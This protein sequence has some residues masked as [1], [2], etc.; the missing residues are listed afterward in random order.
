MI[1]LLDRKTIGILK[2]PCLKADAMKYVEIYEDFLKQLRCLGMSIDEYSN[3]EGKESRQKELK[4]KGAV[5]KNNG[6]S[7]HVNR[8]SPAC[9]A[10]EKGI[11]SRTFFI[12]FN[13]NRD[14]YFCFNYNMKDY[15]YYRSNKKDYVRDLELLYQKTKDIDF[16]GLSGGEPLL[17]IDDV[18]LFYR[19]GRKLF[20]QAYTRLYTNGDYIDGGVLEK[21]RS[22][23]LDEIRFS[24]K[25]EDFYAGRY[26][27]EKLALS[28]KYISSVMVEMPVEPGSFGEMKEILV[29][30]DEVGIFGINLLEMLCSLV[31]CEEYS[32]RSFKIKNP[33]WDVLYDYRYPGTVPIAESELDCLDLLKFVV[34]KGLRLGVHYCS[35]ENKHTAQIYKQNYGKKL[36]KTHYCSNKDYFL[37]SAKV[38]GGDIPEVLRKFK[39]MYY[40]Q[41]KINKK[42]ELVEFNVD[43]IKD[44]KNLDLEVG[45]STSVF[46][47]SSVGDILRELKVDLTY[48]EVF[49][50]DED[51]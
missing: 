40:N 5:F 34:E 19:H 18:V 1:T 17:F 36:P 47:P 8:M 45:I 24:I 42:E 13:C 21:L 3:K 38:Y 15:D 7:I 50:I 11:G 39:K 41:Y 20:P 46:E 31:N 12:S 51:V 27:Y 44:L 30:L 48:P 29:R 33:P 10:C 28:K 25:M 26:I 49:N 6:R 23:H 22:V 43:R 37:K 4:E 35:G 14:C 2:N 16:L 32:A 9:Y